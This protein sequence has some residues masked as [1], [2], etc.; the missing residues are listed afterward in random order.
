MVC[1]LAAV[2]HVHV[3]P[4]EQTPEREKR[5]PSDCRSEKRWRLRTQDE[6][7]HS[8]HR[9][10]DIDEARGSAETVRARHEPDL[11]KSREVVPHIGFEPMISALRGRCPGP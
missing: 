2:H 6:A 1:A 9:R 11:H 7:R 3:A 8:A 5:R 10:A 4:V